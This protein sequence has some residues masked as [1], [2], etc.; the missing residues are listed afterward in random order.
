M[1]ALL[2]EIKENPQETN[3]GGKETKIQTNDLEHKEEINI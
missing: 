2:R 1:K 3:S